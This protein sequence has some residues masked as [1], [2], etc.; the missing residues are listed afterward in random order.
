ML[1]DQPS[2]VR[3]RLLVFDRTRQLYADLGQELPF[4]FD[5]PSLGDVL[6]D[7][8]QIHRVTGRVED[9]NFLRMQDANALIVRLDR[10]FRDV[11]HLAFQ[12][13]A[14]FADE[15]LGLRPWP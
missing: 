1:N 8:E 14:I 2:H 6:R 10:F 15:K 7:T 5:S 12:R 9:R 3:Q 13:L 11:D 4:L